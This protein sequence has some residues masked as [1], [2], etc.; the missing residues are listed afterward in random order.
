MYFWMMYLQYKLDKY[1]ESSSFWQ[2]HVRYEDKVSIIMN[3]SR[4]KNTSKGP[5]QILIVEGF[6]IICQVTELTFE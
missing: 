1:L 6:A 4:S 3:C 5:H 2:L